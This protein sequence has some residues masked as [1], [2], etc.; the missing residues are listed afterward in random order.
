M[1][2]LV[3][4]IETHVAGKDP[5]P[6][7]DEAYMWGWL[8]HEK[9]ESWWAGCPCAIERGLALYQHHILVQ[10]GMYD[11]ALMHR[12]GFDVDLL[13]VE[14]SMVMA[15]VSGYQD[16]S[17]KGLGQQLFGVGVIRSLE[18]EDMEQ[19]LGQDLFLTR[20]VFEKLR[21]EVV[22]T[23]YD[24]DRSL[25]PMLVQASFRG[26]EIDRDRLAKAIAQ[27]EGAMARAKRLFEEEVEGVSIGSPKQIAEHFGLPSAGREI[28]KPLVKPWADFVLAYRQ[29]QTQLSTFLRPLEKLDK[30]TGLFNLTPNESGEEGATTG[31]LSSK[32]LN[33]QN[34]TPVVQ[35]VYHAP[36]GY[37]IRRGD[38]PQIELRGAAEISQ[39]PTMVEVL[40]DPE[41]DLHQETGDRLF[42]GNRARGKTFNFRELY[43]AGADVKRAYPGFYDWAEQQ[44]GVVQRTHYST[45]PG[46]FY[47]RRYIPLIGAKHARRQAINHP[48]QSHAQYICKAIMAEANRRLRPYLFVNQIHDEIHDFVPEDG[49]RDLQRRELADIMEEVGNEY[50]PT[51]GLRVSPEDIQIS[52]H[53]EPK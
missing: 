53:W 23:A 46:P 7:Y 34:Q 10:H 2:P 22:G 52:K 51:V 43:I 12:A 50:L 9:E 48:V 35:P 40:R 45:S 28:L 26:Y 11:V 21:D 36:E 33:M 16:I 1:N 30:A 18:D 29:H 15:N 27:K 19:R 24:V 13:D 5:D 17:L 41:R 14:D 3:I 47:H 31:R 39:D 4:D 38:L 8:G 49:D 25:I 6:R 37:L 42:R 44:W 32:N 20:R